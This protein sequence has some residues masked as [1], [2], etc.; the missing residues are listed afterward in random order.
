MR[1]VCLY[2]KWYSARLLVVGSSVNRCAVSRVGVFLI[3]IVGSKMNIAEL[4][5]PV[6]NHWIWQMLHSQ[7]CDPKTEVLC[8]A[9]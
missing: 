1:G 3:A 2:F 8:I 9:H 7:T 4:K 6:E 5:K